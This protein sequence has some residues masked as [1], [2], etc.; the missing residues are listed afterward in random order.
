MMPTSIPASELVDLRPKQEAFALRYMETG[1]ATQA[2]RDSYN[3]E[4]MSDG[5]IRVEA[6]RLRH[7][8]NITL[9]I[10]LQRKRNAHRAEITVDLLSEWLIEAHDRAIAAN[11]LGVAVRAV[12]A[13]AKLNGLIPKPAQRVVIEECA[14]CRR[15]KD[16]SS[17]E[18]TERIRQLLQT[19]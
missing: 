10:D 9:T 18:L 5:A 11:S 6:H 2:Y 13:L 16:M 7:S 15:Y 19:N 14:R 12:M 4:N 8:P 1:N 3:A 17:E